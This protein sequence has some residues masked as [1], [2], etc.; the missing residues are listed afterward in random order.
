VLSSNV[1]IALPG[2]W[3]TASEVSLALRYGRPVIAYLGARD[4]IPELPDSV[5]VEG[6]LEKVKEFVRE[7]IRWGERQGNPTRSSSVE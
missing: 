1:V 2:G 3:G 5:R 4:E 7:K 6:D